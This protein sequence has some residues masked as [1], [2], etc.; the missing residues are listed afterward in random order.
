[1]SKA[2]LRVIIILVVSLAVTVPCF[3][4]SGIQAGD[5]SSHVYN[6]WLLGEIATNRLDGL[7]VVAQR[8]NVL[9]DVILGAAVNRFGF[10]TGPKLAM[11]ALVLTLFWSA[12]AL[13][14]TQAGKKAWTVAPCL[15]ILAY[16]WTFHMGF[17]NFYLSTALCFLYLAL[18]YKRGAAS[19][20]WAS[21]VLG[22][23]V[24]A[25]AL[26]VSWVVCVQAYCYIARRLAPRSLPGL[27]VGGLLGVVCAR[28]LLSTLFPTRWTATQG[29]NLMGADQAW[30]YGWKYAAVAVG[31]FY[32]WGMLLL[33]EAHMVGITRLLQNPHLHVSLLTAAAIAILPD[34]VQ[35]P[36]YN[37]SLTYIAPRLSL[38]SG[39]WLC[40][41]VASLDMGKRLG[42]VFLAMA[43]LFFS[44]VYV[45]SRALNGIESEMKALLE[46][47]PRGAL[48]I[49]SIE[50]TSARV[51]PLAHMLDRACTGRCYSY[52]NYEP[53]TL[54][55]RIRADQR[56]RVVLSSYRD[57]AAVIEGTYIVKE[58][59]GTLRQIH[60]CG[61][62]GARL[63][64]SLLKPGEV[65]GKT[66]LR[67]LPAFW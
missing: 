57:C 59:D 11:A 56:S 53:S 2:V 10:E 29:T 44:F 1:M 9:F 19:L 4:Q 61:T 35:F 28:V 34:A 31:L 54:Q 36:Q 24:T 45:D 7:T 47:A 13:S 63:C 27:L 40:S 5:L 15:A 62:D 58:R 22:F 52:A 51:D 41:V 20:V 6:V 33:R 49:S 23:A 21:P 38:L 14:W 32:A 17:C 16:G 8:T 12:F 43:L 66:S 55:F 64:L 60:T 46:D 67:V 65:T 30:V 26:P 25:H 48:F 50:E 18:T 37:H 39:L 3:W 42:A